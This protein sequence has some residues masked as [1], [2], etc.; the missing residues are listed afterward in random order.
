MHSDQSPVI[1]QLFGECPAIQSICKE[2]KLIAPTDCTVLVIG[3]T[4]T[5]KSLIAE[6]IF[7]LSH[8]ADNTLVSINCTTPPESK[9]EAEIFGYNKK[10]LTGYN[11]PSLEQL[12]TINGATLLIDEINE[13]TQEAQAH[14]LEVLELIEK[15]N[16]NAEKPALDIRI[17]A[18]SQHD[19]MRLVKKNKFN[20]RLYYHLNVINICIPPIRKRG[21]DKIRIAEKLLIESCKKHSKPIQELSRDAVNKISEYF[22]PGN[23]RELRNVIERSVIL[24]ESNK[25]FIS[26]LGLDS[27]EKNQKSNS[28]N[29]RLNEHIDTGDGSVNQEQTNKALSLEDYFQQFVLENQDHMNETELAHKLGISRKCLWERRQRLGI[30]KPK[31]QHELK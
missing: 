25:L 16:L 4:G 26:M 27:T 23:F 5:G 7:Q 17:I 3:E 6:Y 24:S 22:W 28:A 29:A 11:E 2:I 13:L 20:K 30:P 9:I 12:G 21:E 15:R 1:D 31:H 10:I 14:F 18:T 8:R 19:L